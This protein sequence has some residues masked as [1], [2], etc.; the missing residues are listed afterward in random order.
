MKSEERPFENLFLFNGDFRV[1]RMKHNQSEEY[2]IFPF[3]NKKKKENK[4][5]KRETVEARRKNVVE[6]DKPL[7]IFK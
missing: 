6:E 4:E 2:F 1:T 7:K 3:G 5:N